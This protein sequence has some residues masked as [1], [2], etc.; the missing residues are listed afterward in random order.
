MSDL[1][2]DLALGNPISEQM[3]KDE[4]FE[5]CDREHSSCNPDCPV[6]F[7]NGNRYCD[8]HK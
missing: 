8:C 1:I 3:I 7:L 2:I 5:I 6:Y 4:L